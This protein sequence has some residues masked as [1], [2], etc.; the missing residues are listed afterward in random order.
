MLAVLLSC[1]TASAGAM[2]GVE[3]VPSGLGDTAW[4]ESSQLSG[5]LVAERDGILVP[6]LRSVGGYTWGRHGVFVGF[7]LA[8]IATTVVTTD[9]QSSSSRMAARPS[10]AYRHW[11]MDPGP[12][13]PLFYVCGGMFGVIPFAAES[14]EGA[15]AEDR[16]ALAEAAK[17]A[18]NRIGG[19]G[20]SLG[21]GAEV[22]WDNSLGLGLR[23]SLI[24]FRSSSSNQQTQTVSSLIRPETA[25]TLSYW[26]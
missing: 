13:R 15:S 22:R 7:S 5:T 24:A 11:L 2:L 19:L 16:A 18:K 3:Y 25:I 4:V 9:N 6:P 14:A 17:Q 20:G 23:T 10:V 1:A 8:R 21:I 26:F 12:G